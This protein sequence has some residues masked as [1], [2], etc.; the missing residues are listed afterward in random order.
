MFKQPTSTFP[1]LAWAETAWKV[2]RLQG[3]VSRKMS[4]S[5]GE[6]FKLSDAPAQPL[7]ADSSRHQPPESCS[8]NPLQ[9]FLP[10]F[11]PKRPGSCCGCR[12]A[13]FNSPGG[14]IFEAIPAQP[15]KAD[16]S[17]HQPPESCSNNPLQHFLSWLG[18]KR[19]GRCRGC[20]GAFQGK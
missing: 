6:K 3:R 13:F 1:M 18:P 14:V 8:N 10:W 5:P 20:K 2:P 19:P 7:K 16:S 15:L 4:L 11:G 9:H 12:G 17:R